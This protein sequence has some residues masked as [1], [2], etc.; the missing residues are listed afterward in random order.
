MKKIKEHRDGDDK[1]LSLKAC[2]IF[3]KY[4]RPNTHEQG[5][6]AADVSLFK[7][8]GLTLEEGLLLKLRFKEEQLVLMA[9]IAEEVI[10]LRDQKG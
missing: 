6:Q 4:A 2:D 10:A 5:D 9:R 7:D 1:A 8:L 3:F